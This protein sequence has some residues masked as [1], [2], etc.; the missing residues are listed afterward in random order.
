[1]FSWPVRHVHIALVKSYETKESLNMKK[2][3]ILD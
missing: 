1:M 3:N 2:S